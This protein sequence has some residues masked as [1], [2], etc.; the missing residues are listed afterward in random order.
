M[1]TDKDKTRE[2]LILVGERLIAQHGVEGVSLRKVNM[3]AGQKNTSAALYHFGDKQG[4]LLAIFEYRMAHVD[5]RRHDLLDQ[6]DDSIEALVKAWILPDIEEINEAEGGSYHAR[7]LAVA[8]HHPSLDFR[9]LWTNPHASSYQR[10]ADGLRKQL[11]ELPEA[12]FSMR[13]GMAMMQSIYAL[14]DQERLITAGKSEGM[15]MPLFVSHLIDVM[16]AILSA[17]LSEQTKRELT[18]LESARGG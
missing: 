15:T 17:P 9:E 4:L 18:L 2:K 8:S 10:I 12:V 6:E 16:V 7:F 13:F 3:E 5:Q 1:V 11:P 14:A